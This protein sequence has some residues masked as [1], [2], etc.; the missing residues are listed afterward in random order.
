[1]M[2]TAI[3]V[4]C[5]KDLLTLF[6]ACDQHVRRVRDALGVR[7]SVCN[8][9]IRIGGD[10]QAVASATEVIEQLQDCVQRHGQ[11]APDDVTRVLACVANGDR[12][13]A[14]APIE[15]FRPG[16]QIRPRTAGQARYV[17]AI[18]AGKFE[19]RV[20]PGGCPS[21][22]PATAWCWRFSGVRR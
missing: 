22:C 7:I 8:G 16:R 10:Q 6:G 1:M 19:P 20:P 14:H 18:R 2:E 15:V 5:S 13:V 3:S 9:Q 12:A 21:Y 4:V 17:E 11:L